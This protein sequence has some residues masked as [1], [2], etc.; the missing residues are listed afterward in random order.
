MEINKE[1]FEAMV[2][3]LFDKLEEADKKMIEGRQT[4]VM[5]TTSNNCDNEVIDQT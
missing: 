4:I 5:P 3:R 1:N 2:E